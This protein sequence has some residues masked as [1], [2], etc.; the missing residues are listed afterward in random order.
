V[1]L[2]RILIAILAIGALL[3]GALSSSD[4]PSSLYAI[5]TPFFFF[6]TFTTATRCRTV[7]D[8]VVRLAPVCSLFTTR[9]PPAF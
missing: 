4:Y 3:F 9:A 5:L 7:K 1:N 2:A 8:E 6:L